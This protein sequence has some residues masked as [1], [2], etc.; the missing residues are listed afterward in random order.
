MKPKPFDPT[1]VLDASAQLMDQWPY[2]L[3]AIEGI[4]AQT[5]A[6]GFTRDQAIVFVLH[7]LTTKQQPQV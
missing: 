1:E 5:M 3:D 2:L 7:V 4:I 6:R